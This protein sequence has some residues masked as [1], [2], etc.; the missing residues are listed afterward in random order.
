M[1][2]ATLPA[3]APLAVAAPA[4]CTRSVAESVPTLAP[5]TGAGDDVLKRNDLVLTPDGFIGRVKAFCTC[6]GEACAY[7]QRLGGTPSTFPLRLL[8]RKA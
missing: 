1:T 4:A 3:P 6:S 8:V 5:M 2:T 7:V